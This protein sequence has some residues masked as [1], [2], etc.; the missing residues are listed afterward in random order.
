WHVGSTLQTAAV[1]VSMTICIG[2]IPIGVMQLVSGAVEWFSRRKRGA[3]SIEPTTEGGAKEPHASMSRRQI[4][5]AA[6]G[7]AFIGATGSMLGWGMVR[8][9]HAFELAEV[10]VRIAGLPRA[11]DGYVIAQVSDLHVG[12]YIGERELD[13][14][15]A[16]VRRAR[17]DLL[18]VTGDMV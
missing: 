3:S 6:A 12:T 8:G 11:L 7:V 14:G 10:P 9:R 13:E 16:L 18:V 5:Q 2:A 1:F 4:V 17:P 15:F